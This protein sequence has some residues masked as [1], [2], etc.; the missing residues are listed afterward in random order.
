[1]RVPL[2]PF[3]IEQLSEL[4]AEYGISLFL[5]KKLVITHFITLSVAIKLI[6][7]KANALMKKFI[8]AHGWGI[9]WEYYGVS[10]T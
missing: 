4:K 8:L 10:L 7:S 2:L 1:M 5:F 9:F 3:D 6:T